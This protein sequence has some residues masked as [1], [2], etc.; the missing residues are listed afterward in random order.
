[1]SSTPTID[2]LLQKQRS[3]NDLL[4]RVGS[5][6]NDNRIQR[7]RVNALSDLLRAV[8][9]TANTVDD[10]KV[11]AA[12]ALSLAKNA[13]GIA[14]DAR[15]RAN[16]A[17]ADGGR[18]WSEFGRVRKIAEEAGGASKDARTRANM[19]LDIG[20]ELR[21]RLG[22][23]ESKVESTSI[24]I[25]ALW[26]EI[27]KI[28]GSL[29]KAISRDAVTHNVMRDEISKAG[30]NLMAVA[31]SNETAHDEFGESL[32]TLVKAVNEMRGYLALGPVGIKIFATN[33][34]LWS[35]AAPSV[36]PETAATWVVVEAERDGVV[37][38]CAA[39]PGSELSEDAI[40]DAEIEIDEDSDTGA[41]CR[42]DL[43][44]E[45]D[46]AF[47]IA[48]RNADAGLMLAITQAKARL[49]GFSE[50]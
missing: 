46:E 30:N 34:R 44:N 3:I 45:L 22:Q 17:F 4:A 6:E 19:A 15:G 29:E 50:G 23:I 16:N 12:N 49:A 42:C 40:E 39:H 20:N 13:A 31:T 1:M 36:G 47:E 21:T 41:P 14:E 18:L 7:D 2:D 35:N 33:N 9:K 32:N 28:G 5:L 10:A 48:Q 37:L 26:V 38:H 24:D 43:F 8:A 25:P 11:T 27:G